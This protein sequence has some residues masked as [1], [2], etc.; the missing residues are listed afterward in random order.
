MERQLTVAYSPQQNGVAE[1][2]NRTIVEMARTMMKEMDIPVEFWAEAVNTAVYV[3]NRCFTTSLANLTPFEAFTGR[4]PSIK[5]LKVFGCVCYTHVP[6]HMRQKFDKKA[7]KGIFMGYGSCEKGYRIYILQSKKIVLSRSVVFDENNKFPWKKGLEDENDFIPLSLLPHDSE[8]ET[9]TERIQ[10]SHG[11][12]SREVEEI[13]ESDVRSSPQSR[14]NTSTPV[15][16]RT[17][18]DIYARCNLSMCEPET[19][20]EAAGE[21]VWQNA[22]KDELEMIEK[23]DTWELVERP[24]GK[25]VI[26]VKWVFKTKLNLDGTINKY[27]ARLV[28]KGYAQKSGIDYNETFAP[29]ARLDTIRTLVALADF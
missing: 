10:S 8:V 27:K 15:K 1:R 21:E 9:Q 3:Q 11:E 6:A 12:C 17:L 19:Y 23:N 26:G 20:A 22:M 16:I 13:S 24:Y 29:V 7:E 5:H 2:K 18:E 28:A 14:F 25:P 4:K